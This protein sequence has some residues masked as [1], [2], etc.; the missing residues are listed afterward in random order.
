MVNITENPRVDGSNP[1][2][3][4]IFPVVNYLNKNQ[5][6][7]KANGQSRALILSKIQMSFQY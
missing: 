7:C 1:S 6:G 2:L 4:T 3:G 5:I